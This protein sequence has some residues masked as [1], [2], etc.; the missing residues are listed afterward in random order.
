MIAYEIDG[1]DLENPTR[2]IR[3]DGAGAAIA[4]ARWRGEDLLIPGA[5]GTLPLDR[6]RDDDID[7][8]VVS[9]TG[10]VTSGG[11]PA[12]DPCGQLHTN[13]RALQSLL[14]PSDGGTISVTKTLT[15]ATTTSEVGPKDCRCISDLE[16]RIESPTFARVLVRLRVY[17]GWS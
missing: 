1:T 15:L 7:E 10:D 17:G 16:P 4:A 3:E 14:I 12:S 11:L 13:I 9:I 2:W 5:P 8:F 6:V